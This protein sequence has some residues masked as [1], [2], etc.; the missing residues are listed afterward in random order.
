MLT[1]TRD[2]TLK[3]IFDIPGMGRQRRGRLLLGRVPRAARLRAA[4]HGDGG[5]GAGRGGAAGGAGGG[6]G[7]APRPLERRL[8]E[9]ARAQ[10][11]GP[12]RLRPTG[13]EP[14]RGR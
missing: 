2:V 13:T 6:G 14:Q 3:I 9:P 4:Q 11:G 12:L 10:N 8:P 7:Q 1:Q 5:V